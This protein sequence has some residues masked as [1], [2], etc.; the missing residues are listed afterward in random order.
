MVMTH[1][2]DSTDTT[3]RDNSAE[4]WLLAEARKIRGLLLVV[5]GLAAGIGLLVVFQARLLSLACHQV[6]MQG[7]GV[8]SVLPFAALLVLIAAGRSLFSYFM[9]SRSAAAAAMVKQAVRGDLYRKIQSLGPA[10]LAGNESGALIE[11]VTRGVDELEPYV[12]RFLPQL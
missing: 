2:V 4:K 5:I 8:S 1:S 9:E 6:V 3:A 10:G 11:T 12:T 7:A